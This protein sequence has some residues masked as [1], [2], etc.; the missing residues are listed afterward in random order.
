MIPDQMQFE[1]AQR[2]VAS[3]A[4]EGLSDTAKVRHCFQVITGIQDPAAIVALGSLSVLAGNTAHML[5]LKEKSD[6][7]DQDAELR[8]AS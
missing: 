1:L 2:H 5:S 3:Q 4:L 8:D 6:Q 7:R